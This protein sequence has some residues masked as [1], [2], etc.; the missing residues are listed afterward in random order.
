MRRRRRSCCG[1]SCGGGYVVDFYCPKCRLAVE[2]DGGYHEDEEVRE[3]D[4]VRTEFLNAQDIE[5]V[6]FGNGEVFA[7]MEKVL[8]KIEEHCVPPL[9]VRGG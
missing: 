8:R 9:G 5:V 6:R 3:N 2:L 7:D 4:A 1:R